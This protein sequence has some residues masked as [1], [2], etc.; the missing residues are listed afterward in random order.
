MHLP[1]LPSL[2]PSYPRLPRP[3][4]SPRQLW[5]Q[6]S[7]PV[8]LLHRGLLPHV[9][10]ASLLLLLPHVLSASLLL[11]L[12]PPLQSLLPR[13]PPHLQHPPPLLPH[14]QLPVNHPRPPLAVL[15]SVGRRTSHPL[16]CLLDRY[17]PSLHLHQVPCPALA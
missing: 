5:A 10:S 1:T 4:L 8:Q 9:L 13:C 12:L 11:L 6:P 7:L 14:L 15:G 3:L 2:D 16:R 17:R